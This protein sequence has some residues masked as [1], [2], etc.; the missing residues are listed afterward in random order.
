MGV[1][2]RDLD[3]QTTSPLE[4]IARA[5][6]LHCFKVD[7]RHGRHGEVPQ[8]ILPGEN[9]VGGKL[10][11]SAVMSLAPRRGMAARIN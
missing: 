8:V 1:A 9:R 10:H 3:T 2:D 4:E 11:L 6:R 7:S 5:L